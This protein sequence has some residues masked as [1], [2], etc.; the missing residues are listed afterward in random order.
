MNKIAMEGRIIQ[1]KN[2]HIKDDNEQTKDNEDETSKTQAGTLVLDEEQS[3]NERTTNR[4]TH[5]GKK[6]IYFVKNK[7]NINIIII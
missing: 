5:K 1:T 6:V 4:K 7:I 3:N 2:K